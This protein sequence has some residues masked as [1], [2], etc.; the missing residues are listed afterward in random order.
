MEYTIQVHS[1]WYGKNCLCVFRS[2]FDGFSSISCIQVNR[3]AMTVV[4]FYESHSRRL[5]G[6]L[7]MNYDGKKTK[8]KPIWGW[9]IL[10][11]EPKR[12]HFFYRTI[13]FA[14]NMITNCGIIF[15]HC[16]YY[17]WCFTLVDSSHLPPTLHISKTISFSKSIR[18]NVMR[19]STTTRT[20]KP[21][22]NS[23]VAFNSTISCTTKRAIR[24]L[25]TFNS[26][27]ST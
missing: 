22:A 14:R 24:Y 16:S 20:S 27:N 26:I 6:N 5:E 4:F 10:W 11:D 17:L 21:T 3:P 12:T 8:K 13:S 18:E 7:V 19:T 23:S 1:I 25:S 2:N 15:S 9:A